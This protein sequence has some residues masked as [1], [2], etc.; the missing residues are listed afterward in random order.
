M[1]DTSKMNDLSSPKP[2]RQ[3]DGLGPTS[4]I[5]TRL[6]ALFGAVQDEPIPDRLLDLL[7]KL[8]RAESSSTKGR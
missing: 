2:R 4:D 5:G 7:E 1:R 8:D 6:R 3:D